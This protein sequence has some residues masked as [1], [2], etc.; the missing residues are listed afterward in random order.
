MIE[1]RKYLNFIK[2]VEGLKSVTRTAW[3]KSG[4]QESTAEHSWRLALFAAIVAKQFP[5]LDQEKVLFMSLVHDLGE[6]YSGDKSA[7]LL[8]DKIEKIKEEESA[9]KKL[10]SFLPEE[11]GKHII[12]VCKEYNEG[13]TK[14]AIFVKA[15]D[16]AETII[17]HNQGKNPSDFDYEF[18]LTY[19]LKYFEQEVFLKSLRAE[20]DRETRNK[21]NQ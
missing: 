19:G 11:I 15:L 17:Q 8:P 14:E 12:D 5:E 9:I 10:A 1:I 6:C 3:M 18:N 20:L 21:L 13:V 7:K 4:R 2:E 16:K